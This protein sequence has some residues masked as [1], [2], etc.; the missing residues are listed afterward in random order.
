MLRRARKHLACECKHA[1]MQLS[2]L[3][4]S[5]GSNADRVAL[6]MARYLGL[7]STN[8]NLLI[9]CG[10]TNVLQ[11]ETCH[12]C[13]GQRVRQHHDFPLVR[14]GRYK[15]G[16]LWFSSV[17]ASEMTMVAFVCGAIWRS[18]SPKRSLASGC[19]SESAIGTIPP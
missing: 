3:L 4:L 14:V 8:V 2:K 19:A 9:I 15:A 1:A 18:I 16:T 11:G 17:H 12:L 6:A 5:A 10:T 7:R 13:S